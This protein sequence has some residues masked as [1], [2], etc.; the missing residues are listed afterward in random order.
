VTSPLARAF[1]ASLLLLLAGC[2]ASS[3]PC[4][5]GK[6][7]CYCPKGATCEQTCSGPDCALQCAN[8]DSTCTLHGGDGAN[9]LCQNAHECN[10]TAGQS[11]MVACQYIRGTC[12]ATVGNGSKVHC[13][14]ATLCDVTCTGACDVDCPSGGKCKVACADPAGCNL[15]CAGMTTCPDGKTLTCGVACP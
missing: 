6:P 11:S 13:E 9:A 15:S 3:S 4:K 5:A 2:H 1:A 7:F 10:V 12:K 14:G 8:G